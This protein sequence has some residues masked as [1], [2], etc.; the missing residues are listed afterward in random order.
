MQKFDN[1]DFFD[2]EFNGHQLSEFDGYVGSSDGGFKTYSVLPSRSYV[3]ERP[4]NTNVT[5][6]FNS[7]LEPRVFDVPVVFEQFHDGDLRSIAKWLDSPTPSKF[8]W[9]ND[10]VYINACLDNQ[11]FNA[12]S[13][14]G[15]DGQIAL[16]FIC[17]DPYYYDNDITQYTLT[18]LTSGQSYTYNNDGVGELEPYMTISCNGTIKIEILDANGDVYTTTNITD[19]VGGVNIDSYKLECTLLS[20]ASHFAYIDSFPILPEGEFSIKV[21]G[22]EL[23]NMS[24]EYRQKYL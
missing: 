6:V 21:T 9:I 14:S 23:N 22:S 19:I 12:Q 5:M 18:S 24:I 2:F 10:T 15:Q 3:T 1:M 11:D 7:S 13:I 20:G 8:Q 17:Y 4:L 16:K